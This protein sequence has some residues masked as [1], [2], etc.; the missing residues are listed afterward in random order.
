MFS[1]RGCWNLLLGRLEFPFRGGLVKPQQ[2]LVI[3]ALW[4]DSAMTDL[5]LPPGDH[6]PGAQQGLSNDPP[7]I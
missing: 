4:S 6:L 7:R 2:V 1:K 5:H 3:C